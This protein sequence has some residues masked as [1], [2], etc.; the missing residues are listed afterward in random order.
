MVVEIKSLF[1]NS[2]DFIFFAQ[3]GVDLNQETMIENVG[4]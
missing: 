4:Y 3:L 2:Q 1:F